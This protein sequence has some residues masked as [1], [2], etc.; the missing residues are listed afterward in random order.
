MQTYTT[1]HSSNPPI[2]SDSVGAFP[3]TNFQAPKLLYKQ[4]SWSP[5]TEKEELWLRRKSIHRMGRRNESVTDED[6]EELKACIEL[7]FGFGPDSPELDPKLS[8][9]LPALRFYC[10]VNKQY[11]NGFS[12]SSSSTSILSDCDSDTSSCSSIFDPGTSLR[13]FS[14]WIGLFCVR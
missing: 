2:A 4:R 12:R 11:S 5:D 13:T 7:G 8:D 3:M 14:G 6:L 1:D 9:A 10:A